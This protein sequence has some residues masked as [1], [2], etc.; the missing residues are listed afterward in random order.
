MLSWLIGLALYTF[1]PQQVITSVAPSVSSVVSALPIAA[2]AP[3]PPQKRDPQRLGIATT[4]DASA[5]VDLKT[6][7]FLF[8]KSADEPMAIASLTKLMTVLVVMDHSPKLSMPVTIRKTD[9]RVGGIEQVSVGDVVTF[10]DAL[11]LTLISSSNTAAAALAHSI[12]MSDEEFAAAMNA[13]A[14][15]MGMKNSTFVEPTGLNAK[16]KA[17]AKDVA[18]LVRT[19]LANEMISKIVL[20]PEY[21]FETAAGRT[22]AVRSTDELLDSFLSRDPYTFMGGKTGYL[23]EAGYCFAAAAKNKDGNGVVAVVLG[24]PSKEQRFNEVK[25]LIYWTFDAYEWGKSVTVK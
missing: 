20:M 18:I 25:Q 3:R 24:A 14:K 12:G 7:A 1:A 2:N 4:A 11:H 15:E 6:G 8:G 16:N 22:R 21:Q 9:I 17:S 10:N 19:A 13:K 5:I 23:E